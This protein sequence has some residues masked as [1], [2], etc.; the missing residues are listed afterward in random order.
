VRWV[1]HLEPIR[2]PAAAI[3]RVLSLAHNAFQSELAG[4]AEYGLA[5]VLDVV[6]E[7]N[8]MANPLQN[9]LAAKIVAVQLNQIE[10][11]DSVAS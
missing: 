2:R 10:R 5:I 9:G 6:I 7:P 4:R 1:L 8:A 3:W 11:V